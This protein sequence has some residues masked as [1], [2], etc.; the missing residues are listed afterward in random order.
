MK[1]NKKYRLSRRDRDLS[2]ESNFNLALRFIRALSR[3]LRGRIFAV[4]LF[5][6]PGSSFDLCFDKG[7]R[8][9]NSKR[10]FLG[11]GVAFGVFSRI[12]VYTKNSSNRACVV[13]K[14]GASFGDYSHIGCANFIEIG[15]HVLCGSN[16]LIIDHNHGNSHSDLSASA[17]QAPR[18]RDLVSKPVIIEDF[19]WIGDGVTILPGAHIKRGA[20]IGANSVVSGVVEEC[21]VFINKV[22]R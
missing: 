5:F 1:F 19:V 20:I 12:E 11:K 2:F 13:I 18:L 4:L 22:A 17:L 21:T 7:A 10:I 8:F 9:I 16:I 3:R 6:G 15:K 14:D